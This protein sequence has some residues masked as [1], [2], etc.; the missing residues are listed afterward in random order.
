MFLYMYSKIL[1]L[2]LNIPCKILLLSLNISCKILQTFEAFSRLIF[3]FE[4][5]ILSRFKC[6]I[7]HKI[8]RIANV[9]LSFR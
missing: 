6:V 7:L 3:Y 4:N 2:S 9:G 1:L 5:I 8:L